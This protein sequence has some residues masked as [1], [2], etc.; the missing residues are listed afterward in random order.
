[1]WNRILKRIARKPLTAVSVAVF[2][3]VL[4]LMLCYIHSVRVEEQKSFD[5]SYASVPVFFKITDLDGSRVT[6][7]KG[8][9]GWMAS[10]LTDSTLIPN[11]SPYVKELHIRTSYD[12][13]AYRR[14]EVWSSKLSKF[15]IEEAPAVVTGISS[16]RV[17]EELTAS[18]GGSLHWYE[19]YDESVFASE[20]FVLVV[21]EELKDEAKMHLNI[22]KK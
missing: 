8:I 7:P 11:L 18:W 3:A 12:D 2:A 9:S 16:T 6:D 5:E 4:T 22:R 15:V 19:G 21:P 13:K 1:M 10:L 17:A 14:R 20:E